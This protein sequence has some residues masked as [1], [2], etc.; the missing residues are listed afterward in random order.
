MTKLVSEPGFIAD[1][2]LAFCVFS[3]YCGIRLSNVG[4]VIIDF[5]IPRCVCSLLYFDFV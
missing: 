2:E 3:H 1:L 4:S 5:S